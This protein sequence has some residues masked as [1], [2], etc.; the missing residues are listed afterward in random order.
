MLLGIDEAGRGPV[1]GPMVIGGLVS[2]DEEVLR[3]LGVRDSKL[4][5]PIRREALYREL[6][7]S[8]YHCLLIVPASAIDLSRSIMTLNDL[9]VLCFSSVVLSILMGRAFRHPSLPEDVDIKLK[10]EN[11]GVDLI[12]LDAADV[13]EKRYGEMVSR[14]VSRFYEDGREIQSM[15]KADRDHPVVGAAS[16]IAKVIRDRI[17]VEISKGVG[18][19]VGSGYPGDMTTREFLFS[20]YRRNGTLPSFARSSWDTCRKLTSARAQRTLGDF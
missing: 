10:G 7:G 6:E 8:F 13:N 3:E 16:I 11:I 18:E 17:M 4:L 15:H 12:I 1:L 20:Y 19:D 5:T 14:E 9:E 2:N